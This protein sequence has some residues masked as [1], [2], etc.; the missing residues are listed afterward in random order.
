MI[1]RYLDPYLLGSHRLFRV[2]RCR[3]FGVSGIG[4]SVGWFALLFIH[5][6]LVEACLISRPALDMGHTEERSQCCRALK[7]GLVSLARGIHES[8]SPQTP[9]SCN[10][11]I[12]RGGRLGH[13][14][15]PSSAR[16]LQVL[17]SYSP[18]ML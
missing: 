12:Y 16:L 3:V 2:F 5:M 17:Q 13:T 10:C 8:T 9:Q 1:N 14:S 11:G 7:R 6:L 18:F 4:F 15:F